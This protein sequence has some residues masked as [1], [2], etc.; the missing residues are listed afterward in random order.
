MASVMNI[1]LTFS[2]KPETLTVAK[3]RS[4]YDYVLE[5]HTRFVL[6]ND[7]SII[8]EWLNAND[9]ALEIDYINKDGIQ[10]SNSDLD[11]L[12]IEIKSPRVFVMFKTEE[13]MLMFKLK[14]SGGHSDDP[15]W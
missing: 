9:S 10:V 3:P 13:T 11:S 8:Q 4:K 12:K 2:T 7:L 5:C 6:N 15:Q 1:N 14:F